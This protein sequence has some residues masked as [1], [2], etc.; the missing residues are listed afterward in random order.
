MNCKIIKQSGILIVQVRLPVRIYYIVIFS[1][2][3]DVIKVDEIDSAL[4]PFTSKFCK[5]TLPLIL[6]SVK[7]ENKEYQKGC[8][9]S[10]KNPI[11]S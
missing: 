2:V 3:K 1:L 6:V 9:V 11:C 8:V 5:A 7:L 4:I 10:K